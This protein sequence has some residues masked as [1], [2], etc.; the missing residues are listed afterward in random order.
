MPKTK[1]LPSAQ[2]LI[3]STAEKVV[4]HIEIFNELR[5]LCEHHTFNIL[6][7]EHNCFHGRT[8]T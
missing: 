2:Y 3:G 8:K 7:K 4:K 5:N 1:K 6:T